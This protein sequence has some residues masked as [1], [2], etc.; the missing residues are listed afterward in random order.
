[1]G[2]TLGVGILIAYIILSMFMVAYNID[3]PRQ[4]YGVGTF[5][6]SLVIWTL[7]ILAVIFI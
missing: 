6:L 5:I 3:R 1:M 4:P 7:L 2:I